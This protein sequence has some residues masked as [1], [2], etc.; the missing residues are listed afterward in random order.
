MASIVL[1]SSKEVVV[2]ALSRRSPPLKLG[3]TSLYSCLVR[4]QPLIPMDLHGKPQ[5]SALKEQMQEQLELGNPVV[6]ILNQRQN[7]YEREEHEDDEKSKLISLGQ[8][9]SLSTKQDVPKLESC[10][11]FHDEKSGQPL[12]FDFLSKSRH[13][14]NNPHAQVLLNTL[15]T[16]KQ[17]VLVVCVV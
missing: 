9:N 6:I 13:S 2:L 11:T 8:T 7:I 17:F 5:N 4:V 10:G 3:A 12:A 16:I 1:Y 14:T 15:P